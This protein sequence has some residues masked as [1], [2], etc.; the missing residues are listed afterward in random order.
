MINTNVLSSQFCMKNKAGIKTDSVSLAL[1]VAFTSVLQA[2]T[3]INQI[4]WYI[5]SFLY[6]LLA[7]WL[8]DYFS[9]LPRQKALATQ[10]LESFSVTGDTNRKLLLSCMPSLSL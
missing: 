3:V 1:E 6:T 4:R 10:I 2:L 8:K 7:F 5:S 9:D